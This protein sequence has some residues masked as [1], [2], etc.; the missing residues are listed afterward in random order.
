MK[1]CGALWSRIAKSTGKPFITGIIDLNE[2]PPGD[3]VN[4]VVFQNTRKQAANSPDY[5]MF[6]SEPAKQKEV[7]QGDFFNQG[8]GEGG[9]MDEDDI[10]F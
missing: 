1:K 2:M 5:L 4:V 7:S 6:L 10:P 8:A 9:P 3:K